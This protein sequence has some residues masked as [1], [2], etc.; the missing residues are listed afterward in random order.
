MVR[1]LE[2]GKDRE[3]AETDIFGMS[4]RFYRLEIMNVMILVIIGISLIALTATDILPIFLGVGLIAVAAGL[5]STVSSIVYLRTR[6][7]G[8]LQ[9]QVRKSFRY[10]MATGIICFVAGAILLIAYFLR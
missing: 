10:R 8:P 4:S 7:S 1:K 2:G 5:S 6:S 3:V 9:N